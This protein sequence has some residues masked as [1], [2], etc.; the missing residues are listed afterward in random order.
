MTY[1][2][3]PLFTFK[4]TSRALSINGIRTEIRIKDLLIIAEEF[5]IKNP[6]GI[7]EEVQSIIPRWKVVAR[8]LEI[9]ENIMYKI[10]NDLDTFRTRK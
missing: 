4:S 6:K 8:E 7:I 5:A 1:A 9:P 10:N 2:L 3:N